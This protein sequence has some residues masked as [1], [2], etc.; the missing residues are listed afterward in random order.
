MRK[1]RILH[2]LESNDM[3]NPRIV[4]VLFSSQEGNKWTE[5]VAWMKEI[6]NE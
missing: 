2:N 5:L 3:C 4:L 1:L 6:R